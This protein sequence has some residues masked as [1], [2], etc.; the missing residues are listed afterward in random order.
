M[1]KEWVPD[2]IW[3]RPK[4]PYRAPIHRSFVESSAHTYVQELLAPE[5]ISAYDLF[6][7]NAV[8]QLTRKAERGPRFSETDDM[9]LLG[10]LSTQLIYQMF[11]D[12][13]VVPEPVADEDNLK[14]CIRGTDAN[15]RV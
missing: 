4:T 7:T 2:E 9:A 6:N 14:L 5:T 10:V 12:R 3:Q 15:T 13:F 8:T 11:I 1:G